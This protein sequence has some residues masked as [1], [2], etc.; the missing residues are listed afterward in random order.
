M[1]NT[2]ISNKLKT[3]VTVHVNGA[4]TLKVAGNNTVSNIAFGSEIITGCQI[5]QVIYGAGNS[6][7]WVVKRANTTTNT[8]VLVLSESGF[9][10]F[11]GSGM[12]IT[13]LRDEDDLQFE[14][15]G[16]TNGHIIIEL[17]KLGVNPNA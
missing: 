5:E 10:D 4:G 13:N 8:V 1:P 2:V 14:M 15:V 3:S 12:K 17:K 7:S 16:T 11:S 9:M 6:G